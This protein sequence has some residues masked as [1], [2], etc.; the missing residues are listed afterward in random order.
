[1]WKGDPFYNKY[2]KC[3]PLSQPS[4]QPLTTAPTT[5]SLFFDPTVELGRTTTT[6][7]TTPNLEHIIRGM[8]ISGEAVECERA[9]QLAYVQRDGLLA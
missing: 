3:P 4:L 9:A 7:M 8:F 1:M 2:S 5:N 6:V